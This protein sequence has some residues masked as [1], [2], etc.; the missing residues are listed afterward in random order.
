MQDGNKKFSNCPILC[1][2]NEIIVRTNTNSTYPHEVVSVTVRGIRVR[3]SGNVRLWGVWS[4]GHTRTSAR[5]VT[6]SRQ[7][8]AVHV[9]PKVRLLAV[10]LEST[11]EE[12]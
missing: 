2:I 4:E 11:C 1:K 6:P 5:K 7:R 3:D 12:R 9:E 10:P 8:T